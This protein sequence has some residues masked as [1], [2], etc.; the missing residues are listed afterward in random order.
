MK[1]QLIC[2]LSILMAGVL[3]AGC[4]GKGNNQP[5][6]GT[7][8][9]TS[10]TQTQTTEAAPADT[11]YSVLVVDESD[12]PVSGV[13]VQFC[14]DA[15]CNL[16]ETGNDGIA[17]FQT[18]APGKY[19]IHILDIP[20]GFEEDTTEYVTED[21]YGQI[22]VVLKGGAQASESADKVI[23]EQGGVEIAVPDYFKNLKGTISYDDELLLGDGMVCTQVAY[24]GRSEEEAKEFDERLYE[25]RTTDD[26]KVKEDFLA[27]MDEY[28]QTID[29]VLYFVIATKNGESIEDILALNFDEDLP[30]KDITKDSVDLGKKGDYQYYLLSVDYG[31]VKDIYKAIYGKDA[32][33]AS[34]EIEDEY[35]K[36]EAVDI[37]DFAKCITLI[38]VVELK[39]LAAGDVITFEGTDFEGNAVNSKDIF[40]ENKYTMINIWATWCH[41]CIDELP[42]LEEYNKELEKDGCAII[43]VCEDGLKQPEMAQS[44]LSENSVTYT[45]V[46][47]A[48]FDNSF[49]LLSAFPT[50][51]IVDSEGKIVCDPIA[52]AKLDDYKEAMA[53]A[54]ES[55]K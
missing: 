15:A 26:M 47:P 14:D 3:L 28:Q 33:V 13:T 11:A 32:P 35:A 24:I 29:T 25:A 23:L 44:I 55:L 16:G 7:V 1:K 27:Y 54:L 30:F 36:L 22:K 6:S 18:E 51:Y 42:D 21:T 31:T 38:D 52:G 4:S 12:T 45:N 46:I 48:D 9:E 2:G 34:P 8:T 17:V 37:N 41:W 5:G 43:G 10:E 53:K 19:T 50:T 40:A 39:E 20:E 49:P